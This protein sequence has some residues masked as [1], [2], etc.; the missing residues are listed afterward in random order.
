[1]SAYQ[2]TRQI[3]LFDLFLEPFLAS[4]QSTH[5]TW[6]KHSHELLLFQR[7][8]FESQA[9]TFF[10]SSIDRLLSILTTLASSNK[11]YEVRIIAIQIIKEIMKPGRMNVMNINLITSRIILP[12]LTWQRSS[13]SSLLRV[14]TMQCFFEI[15]CCDAYMVMITSDYNQPLISSLISNL[16][17]D[18]SQTRTE[19]LKCIEH[20][21]DR[22]NT[23]IFD[24]IH[25]MNMYDA[26]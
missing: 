7:I 23:R 15:I 9:C 20:L 11:E 22:S 8:V 2:F 24:G 3:Q 25:Y 5:A 13:E 6:T 17:D 21:L 19:A 12:N 16:N 4:L 1:M 14:S 26:L 18:L 10:P